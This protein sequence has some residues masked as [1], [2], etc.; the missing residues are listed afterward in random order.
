MARPFLLAAL[1]APLLA[2][3]VGVDQLYRDVERRLPDWLP[4]TRTGRYDAADVRRDVDRYVDDVDR[5][6]RLD[7]RQADD[8]ARLLED[9]TYDLLERGRRDD[10]YGDRYGADY[11][12]PRA[13]ASRDLDRWWDDADRAIERVLD[14]RQR[15]AY[16]RFV[17]DLEGYDDDRWDD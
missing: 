3:C 16:R 4:D 15:D 7:R 8:V 11:P 17:R 9:R 6:V 5:A 13:R 2:G 12:F 14:G 10:R 1:A